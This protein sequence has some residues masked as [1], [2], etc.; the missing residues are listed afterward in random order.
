MSEIEKRLRKELREIGFEGELFLSRSLSVEQQVLK[1]LFRSIFEERLKI[2]SVPRRT[3]KRKVYRATS[4]EN[5]LCTGL[6]QFLE[7]KEQKERFRPLMATIP[8]ALILAYAKRHGL[9]G[10][11]LAPRDDVRALL[12]ELQEAQPQTKAS[13]RKSLKWLEKKKEV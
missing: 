3:R 6:R 5:E 10:K 13:L 7:N 9:T 1:E 2:T 12:D 4:L 8:E 11:P